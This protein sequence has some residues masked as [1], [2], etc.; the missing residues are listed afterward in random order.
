MLAEKGGHVMASDYI[1]LTAD[2]L[3]SEHLCCAIADKKHR[4]GVAAKKAWLRERLGEGHVFRKLDEKGKVFIE[5][6]P[7]ETAWTPVVGECYMYIYCLWVSGSFKGKG[8]GRSLLE[9]CVADAKRRGMSGVCAISAKK[10]KPFLS[11]KKFLEKF[12][13]KTADV[14]DDYELLALAFDG[15]APRFADSVRKQ[16]IEETNLTVYY[17]AQCPYIPNCISEIGDYCKDN[18]IPLQL[19]PVDTLEKAKT[20]PCVFNNWA[21]FF[22]GRFMT[23]HLLNEGYLKK[24]LER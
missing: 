6:A 1:N 24:L 18:D 2:N 11:D 9:Y 14:L 17:S 13:F 10:K 22:G 21:V 8:H 23:V 20:V 7:L 19:E 12:G 5:Y 3:D 15:S 4:D 16:A